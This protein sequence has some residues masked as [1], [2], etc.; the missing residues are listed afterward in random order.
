MIFPQ[1][2][3]PGLSKCLTVSSQ[4]PG[5]LRSSAASAA[6]VG[7]GSAFSAH[8]SHKHCWL[9]SG[10]AG[11][12]GQVQMRLKVVYEASDSTLESFFYLH[13][14]LSALREKSTLLLLLLL[15]CPG[16]TSQGCRHPC[17]GIWRALWRALIIQPRERAAWLWYQLTWSTYKL[18]TIS[19][20]DRYCFL[21]H[22]LLT[23]NCVCLNSEATSFG[24]KLFRT[25][26]LLLISQVNVW[27]MTA[28]WNLR[29]TSCMIHISNSTNYI[30]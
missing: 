17:W 11:W 29:C 4:S 28:Q 13:V 27:K 7:P 8:T 20:L 30:E 25:N 21:L 12:R 14:I 9:P 1:R 2:L 15:H 24:L 16:V 18:T 6:P 10:A 3:V 26:P 23:C 19:S 5:P 22:V